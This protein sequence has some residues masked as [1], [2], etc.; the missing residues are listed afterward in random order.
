VVSWPACA[1]RAHACAQRSLDASKHSSLGIPP[2]APILE[3][4]KQLC[5]LLN[6]K[7]QTARQWRGHARERFH[8]VSGL[9]GSQLGGLQT[10]VH[11][12]RQWS[13]PW[14]FTTNNAIIPHT[15]DFLRKMKLIKRRA[16]GCRNFHNYLQRVIAHCG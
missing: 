12:L 1:D 5:A 3:L 14:R 8:S 16:Y 11:T 6:Q 7:T 15:R 13:E 2:L 10:L 9:E 4:R